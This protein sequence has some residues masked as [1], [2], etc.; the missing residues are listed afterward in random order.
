MEKLLECIFAYICKNNY[1][2]ECL[3][4][5][6]IYTIT[7]KASE[8]EISML[9][10]AIQNIGRTELAK[11]DTRNGVSLYPKKIEPNYNLS[12]YTYLPLN[13]D[14]YGAFSCASLRRSLRDKNIRGSK[15]LSHVIV[16]NEVKD[17]FY[18]VDML[19]HKHFSGFRDIRLND[20]AS[21]EAANEDLV[22]EIRPDELEE[23][24]WD[25]FYS[26]PLSISDMPRTGKKPL[27]IIAEF[28]HA[29]ITSVKADKTLYIVYNPEEYDEVIE[30]IKIGL[31]LFPARIANKLSFVTALGKTSRVNVNICGIPTSDEEYISSLKREGN[32]IKITGLDTEFLGG[33]KGSFASF[34]DTA[35]LDEFEAWLDSLERYEDSIRSLQD[36]D[37]V[38][39]LYK[40]IIGKEFDINNPRQAL[41]DV[42]SCI[43]V[44]VDKFNIVA[45]IDNEIEAQV[46]GISTQVKHACGAFEEYSTYD[47]EELLIEPILA[48][49]DKCLAGT[50]K[51]SGKVIALLKYVL[52]GLP[53]QNKELERRHYEFFSVSHKKVKQLLDKNY[54]NFVNLIESNWIELKVFFDSYLNEPN[55][56]EISAE[57]T[58]SLLDYLLDDLS[59]TRRSRV[60]VRNYFVLQYL[61]KNPEKFEEI[62]KIIFSRA[63]DRLQE[64][65]SYI[66]DTVI[67]T[68]AR[69][70]LLI[71]RIDFLCEY[72]KNMGLLNKAI[73]YVRNRYTKQFSE[74]EVLNLVFKGLL[75]DYLNISNS[76]SFA[77]IYESYNK[78]QN[79]LGE[80]SSTSLKRFVYESFATSVLIPNYEK[81][82][83]A[84]RFEDWND[85]IVEKYTAFAN[86]LNS[87]SIKGLIPEKIILAIE[88]VLEKYNIFK[89]Q[90]KRENEILKGRIDFVAREFLLLENKTIYKMLV[91]HIGIDKLTS[92]LQ[93]ANIEGKAYK[94]PSFLKFAEREVQDYL[95]DKEVNNK[96]VFCNEVREERKRVFRDVF[97]AGKDF[98]GSFIGSAIFAV[99]MAVIASVLGTII[100]KNLADSYF[101]SIYV[102]F[103]GLTLIVSFILYWTNYKDRRLRNMFLMSLWQSL[104]FVLATIGLFTLVQYLFILLAL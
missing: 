22:C 2:G 100:Y 16:F 11:I 59:N 63:D 62:I 38:A 85:A 66:F 104:L 19:Q 72:I 41:V 9:S 20:A 46:E 18:V 8:K 87:P 35:T 84:V 71:N 64:E 24:T 69:N 94:H 7:K 28:V 76:N 49:Y 70:E 31:K 36:I 13:T 10:E 44:V 53:G 83:K 17:D 101:K 40:N 50:Y 14:G 39:A 81:A 32:V 58:L 68:N 51:V 75:N 52:F 56:A 93:V 95:H 21:I 48:L 54:I 82:L 47:V 26:R 29:L 98:L 33:D 23:L 65:F 3:P 5:D 30:N 77:D 90:T 1:A 91:K 86:Q 97:V 37:T 4:A 80:N 88:S 103:V 67:K 12:S 15:E 57:I 6:Q 89:T 99:L 61:Q 73:E 102:I 60:I 92:D 96:L 74:D 78:I 45:R 55:Y 34:L 27:K 25:N 42:S 79:L 43:N